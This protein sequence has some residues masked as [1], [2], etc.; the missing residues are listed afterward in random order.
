MVMVWVVPR[1]QV[2]VKTHYHTSLVVAELAVFR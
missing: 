1:L 2:T